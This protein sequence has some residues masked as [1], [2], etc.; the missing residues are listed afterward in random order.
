MVSGSPMFARRPRASGTAAYRE[1]ESAIRARLLEVAGDMSIAALASAVELNHESVRRAVR[2]G[3]I[4]TELVLRVCARFNVS[5]DWLL[6]GIGARDDADIPQVLELRRPAHDRDQVPGEP[7]A[8]A[9][10]P[11][12]A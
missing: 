10:A 7:E 6:F 3:T 5:A 9:P 11:T 1:V 12:A 8:T 4:R 2:G